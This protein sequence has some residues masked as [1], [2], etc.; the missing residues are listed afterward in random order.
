VSSI[1]F[2]DWRDRIRRLVN[3]PND[4]TTWRLAVLRLVDP[5]EWY[6]RKD[7]ERARPAPTT[8]SWRPRLGRLRTAQV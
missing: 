2:V 6:M 7:E 5:V 1:G 4:L 8:I 3:R